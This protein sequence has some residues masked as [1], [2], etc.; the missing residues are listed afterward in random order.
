M[1]KNLIDEPATGF[2]CPLCQAPFT[3]SKNTISC[4]N[5]H[6]YNIT[7]PGTINFITKKMN[8]HS[9]EFYA[10]EVKFHQ[11]PPWQTL[12]ETIKAELSISDRICLTGSSL[13]SFLQAGDIGFEAASYSVI[14]QLR[15]DPTKNLFI[16]QAAQLP[17]ADEAMN[18][19]LRLDQQKAMTEGL[20]ILKPDHFMVLILPGPKHLL[21]VR[22]HLFG[23][24]R[25]GLRENQSLLKEIWAMG[26][27][28]VVTQ[29]RFTLSYL[30]AKTDLAIISQSLDPTLEAG[31]LDKIYE[32]VSSV[33]FDFL[34]YYLK[35][36]SI[37]LDLVEMPDN[38]CERT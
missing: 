17:L 16:A 10:T 38:S 20:R 34:V 7:K 28:A 32:T 37:A 24:R 29:N 27:K 15:S 35:K 1:L 21:E 4:C 22:Q 6:S 19:V 2:V 30:P 23:G 12:I 25:L 5:G 14:R 36:S 3:L 8:T 13:G 18:L 31:Q 11:L 26:Q 33:T 9:E